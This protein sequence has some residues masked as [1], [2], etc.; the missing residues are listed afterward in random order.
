MKENNCISI[1]DN[2]D[3]IISLVV[4]FGGHA[5][6]FEFEDLLQ[7]AFVC[8]FNAITSFDEN[9]GPLRPYVFSSVKNH[10]NRFLRKEL[11]W[12]N[13]NVTNSTVSISHEDKSY[14]DEFK[15]I[16]ASCSKRLLPIESFI[17][18]MKSQ[19]FNRKEICDT[20]T[21]SKKEYYNLFYSGVGKIQRYET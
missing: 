16:L 7:V 6:S 21:L 11:R 4:Q 2:F 18:E 20:L 17:L 8:Y 14:V 3:I 10:L 5:K 1:D 9:I 19:G 13:N 12:Q 15:Q